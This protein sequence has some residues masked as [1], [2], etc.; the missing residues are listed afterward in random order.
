MSVITAMER[1]LAECRLWAAEAMIILAFQLMPK[2][3][4][5]T[6]IW[7]R[8]LLSA[9]DDLRRWFDANRKKHP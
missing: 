3:R 9:S 4:P 2:G 8:H 7:A 6:A 1:A 5:E